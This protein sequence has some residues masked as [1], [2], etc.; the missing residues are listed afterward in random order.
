MIWI[1][2]AFMVVVVVCAVAGALIDVSMETEVF[3][4]AAGLIVG[5]WLAWAIYINKPIGETWTD[6]KAEYLSY[7]VNG[8]TKSFFSVPSNIWRGYLNS[9][10]SMNTTHHTSPQKNL[11]P[12][13][14][15]PSLVSLCKLSLSG[16]LPLGRSVILTLQCISQRGL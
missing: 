6:S 13:E 11:C 14:S 7:T 1:I 10:T 9:G 2:L 4:L 12:I 8:E 16:L 3:F 5:I 15:P